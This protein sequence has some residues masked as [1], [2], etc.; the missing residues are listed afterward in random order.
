MTHSDLP[1]KFNFYSV[2]W[3]AVKQILTVRRTELIERL[4]ARNDDE[5]RGRIKAIDEV[6]SLDAPRAATETPAAIY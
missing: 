1:E 5:L 6:L 4:V 2:E 3:Q